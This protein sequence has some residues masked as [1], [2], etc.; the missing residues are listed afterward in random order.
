LGAVETTGKYFRPKETPVV[1]RKIIQKN[2]S[3]PG[4]AEIIAV[5]GGVIF[6]FQ[7]L[8]FAHIQESILD[9]GLYLVKGY[10]FASGHYTPF[11][12]MA[13]GPTRCAFL[14]DPCFMQMLF[15]SGLRSGRYFSVLLGIL[16]LVGLWIIA[17]RWRKMVAAGMVWI[18]AI[19]PAFANG[20]SMAVSQALVA[21]IL[22]LD[23]CAGAR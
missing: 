7:A 20:Y 18:V 3:L 4:I 2:K 9:E 5:I 21:C 11:Q 12:P 16:I 23:P 19:N 6:M 1:N 14:S 10:L 13:P 15:G 8:H 17:R 22:T